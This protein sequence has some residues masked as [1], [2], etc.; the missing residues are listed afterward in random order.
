VEILGP[1][2]VA[3]G[4]GVDEKNAILLPLSGKAEV[5]GQGAAYFFTAA[6]VPEVC[7][8]PQ[9]NKQ[10]N[11][12]PVPLT[13]TTVKTVKILGTTNGNYFHFDHSD[14]MHQPDH[15]WTGSGDKAINVVVSKGVLSINGWVQVPYTP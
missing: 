4:V 8:P 9:V 1:G 14:P 10:G 2:A 12:V 6:K 5:V 13:Y 7:K 3:R 15:Y 11:R